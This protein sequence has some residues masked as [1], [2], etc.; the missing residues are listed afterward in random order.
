MD[1]EQALHQ[2]WS[3]FGWSARDE[4]TVP[5][6][7][8]ERFG[9]HYITYALSTAALDERV[10]LSANLWCR[11]SSWETITEKANAISEA[12]GIGGMVIPFDDGYLWICRGA[13]FSQRLDSGDSTIRRIYINLMAEY[14]SAN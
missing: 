8:M 11:D 14:L 9:G 2:F 13:P 4:N 7:A 1:K 12:I 6:D 10:P 5:D 3:R